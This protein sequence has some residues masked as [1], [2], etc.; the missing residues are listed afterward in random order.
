MKLFVYG[1]AFVRSF[2]ARSLA[3]PPVRCR[4]QT[5][6]NDSKD[7]CW[8]LESVLFKPIDDVNLKTNTCFSFFFLVL[9]TMFAL[10]LFRS[11]V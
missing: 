9:A 3:R 5:L 7:S 6:S 4:K 1:L 8:L 10:L 11:L 2:I